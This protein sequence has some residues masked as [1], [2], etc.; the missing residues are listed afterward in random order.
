MFS[1][2]IDGYARED[3]F[4]VTR[5][6]Y[7]KTEN[8]EESKMNLEQAVSECPEEIRRG[9]QHITFLNKDGEWEIWRFLGDSIDK[10]EDVNTYWQCVDGIPSL[11]FEITYVNDEES[12]IDPLSNVATFGGQ[13]D[14]ITDKSNM[15]VFGFGGYNAQDA[16]GEVTKLSEFTLGEHTLPKATKTTLGGIKA[17]INVANLAE[18]ATIAQVAGAVNT[19]LGQF[20]NCGLIQ[21]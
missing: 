21:L 6:K 15:Q 16:D 10:W 12:K 7:N 2:F 13:F 18:N 3:F 9:G 8:I 14:M 1:A 11:G 17:I 20:R 19:L 4:N 5:Y